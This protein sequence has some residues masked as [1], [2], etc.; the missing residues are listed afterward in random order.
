M[1]KND[2]SECPE[3]NKDIFFDIKTVFH[4]KLNSNINRIKRFPNEESEGR[5]NYND[6]TPCNHF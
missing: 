6:M 3:R 2:F 1:G 5:I 4:A